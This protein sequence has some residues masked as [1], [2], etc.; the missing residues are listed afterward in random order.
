MGLGEINRG[1]N[2]T[3]LKIVPGAIIAKKTTEDDI[4]A[5]KR[6]YEDAN[7][8]KGHVFE[9]QFDNLSGII[10]NISF[11]K[12]NYGEEFIILIKDDGENYRLS[13]NISQI[14]N[15][16]YANSF[17]SKLRNIDLTKE[18]T[19]KPYDFITKE[20][21]KQTGM[22]V[23]QDG[24]K[25]GNSYYDTKT[26]KLLVKSFPTIEN[27]SESTQEDRDMYNLQLKSFYK[28]EVSKLKFPE[29]PKKVEKK[30]E[31]VPESDDLP[32]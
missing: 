10:S 30:A 27:W 16:L 11:N 31:D 19:L 13:M 24:N 8:K 22:T 26:K 17:L 5:V 21:K 28:K 9:R 20:G 12:G 25:L 23:T 3:F 15:S 29:T 1:G 2:I 32:F 18:V 6:E 7:G 4:R 14:K